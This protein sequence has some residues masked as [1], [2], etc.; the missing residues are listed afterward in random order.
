M[1][2]KLGI[3][4]EAFKALGDENRLKLLE[5][6]GR[7]EMFAG[8]LLSEL[9]I[10]QPTLSHH[11]KILCD[12]GIVESRREGKW[13]YYKISGDGKR[14]LIDSLNEITGK[15]GKKAP[16]ISKAPKKEKKVKPQKAIEEILEE[17]KEAEI[18]G[19]PKDEIKEKAEE[20]PI[21]PDIKEEIIEEEKKPDRSMPSW[22]F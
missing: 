3:L 11:M 22:L 8:E 10:S 21:I 9:S 5:V 6:L 16:S 20:I 7:G 2:S 19:E 1:K 17:I 15:E 14:E 13:I 18:I 12:S 4:A